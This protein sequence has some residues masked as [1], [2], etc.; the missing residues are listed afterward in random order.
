VARLAYQEQD[1]SEV[2]VVDELG[3]LSPED[4]LPG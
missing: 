3:E 1:M 4:Q 2:L